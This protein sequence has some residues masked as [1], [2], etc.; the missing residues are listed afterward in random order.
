MSFS[1][2]DFSVRIEN[3][4]FAWK[5]EDRWRSSAV[6]FGIGD[7]LIGTN[8]LTSD[9]KNEDKSKVRNPGTS[10][11]GVE[12]EHGYGTWING[13]VYAAPLYVGVKNGGKVSRVGYS[14]KMVQE[15]TQNMVH[16]YLGYQNYYTNYKHMYEGGWGSQGH[17]NPYSLY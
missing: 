16:R 8:I 9:P 11:L 3:D 13:H 15:L 5:D 10:L 12:N 2:G 6:E 7:I 14:H 4:F 17:Y 1:H